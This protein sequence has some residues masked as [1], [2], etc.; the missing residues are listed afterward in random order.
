MEDFTG[1]AILLALPSQPCVVTGWETVPGI[2]Q[3]FAAVP[4]RDEAEKLATIA[5]QLAPTALFARE[6]GAVEGAPKSIAYLVIKADVQSSLEAMD[7]VLRT[8]KSEEVEYRVVDYGVGKI[9]DADVKNAKAKGAAIIG[10]HVP[11]EAAAKQ[12]AERERVRIETR[13]IIYE[14]VELV[15]DIMSDFLPPEIRRTPLG[16]LKVLALF[17][18]AANPR[19]WAVKSRKAKRSAARWW[20]SRATAPSSLPASS[21]SFSRKKQMSP[22]SPRD[23][24]AACATTAPWTRRCP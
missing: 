23:L 17:G 8:I 24:N 3:K 10:F 7:Q 16:K 22:K 4:S 1:K 6:Q 21:S 20:R 9:G 5:A 14:L 18:I 11:I 12:S 15:R 13:D 19:S 2:G